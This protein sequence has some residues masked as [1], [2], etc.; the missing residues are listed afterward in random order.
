[1]DEFYF[2]HSLRRVLSFGMEQHVNIRNPNLLGTNYVLIDYDGTIYPTDEARMLAR[3]GRVDLSIGHVATG[4][5]TARREVLNTASM[6]NFDPDC[7]HCIYQPFC[8][9][10][11]VDD[12]SRYGRLDVPR[13]ATWFCQRQMAVFDKIMEL[14]Y[15]DDDATKASLAHWC[16]I[17]YWPSGLARSH[18]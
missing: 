6:N 3:I 18:T 2:T 7:I 13:Y 17:A 1:M 5:D 4:I 15:R 12:L 10:D 11:V 9:T 16:G 8:G 14:I